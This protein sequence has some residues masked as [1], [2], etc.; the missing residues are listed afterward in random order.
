MKLSRFFGD[1]AFYETTFRI[2]LPLALST[3]LSSCMSTIDSLMASSIGM[4]TAVGNASQ[5]ITLH[6]GISFGITSGIAIFAAQFYGA[7]Q[8]DNMTRVFG[9]SLIFTLFNALVWISVFLFMGDDLLLFYLDDTQ[10][11]KYSLDYL[12][13]TIFSCIP[14]AINNSMMVAY[15]SI[16]ETKLTFYFSLLGAI[17]NV[18]FNALFIY[19]FKIGVAGAALGTIISQT[20]VMIAYLILSIKKR[21]FFLKDLR[22]IFDLR[23]SFYRPIIA[24]ML[25]LIINETLFSFGSTLFIKAF[26]LLGTKNMD[27]YYVAN[28]IY[29]LFLFIVWGYGGAVSILIGTRLGSHQI[30]R[31]KEESVY[32]ISLSLIIA[33]IIAFFIV[34]FKGPILALYSVKDPYVYNIASGLLYVLAFKAILRMLTYVIFS[35]LRAGGDAKILNFLDSGITYLLGIP[36]AFIA[37]YCGIQ[38]IVLVLLLCQIEQVVRL[39]LSLKR[40]FKGIWA[41]DLTELIEA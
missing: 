29:N 10:V 5:I 23:P 20:I 25:P 27:A 33:F 41:K 14:F 37:V 32:Q 38:S 22:L 12:S 39:I 35:T 16:H 6:D 40:Y 7:R 11:L 30:E 13:I 21:P 36:S 4:V 19:G 24:K 34:I 8:A 3:L 17:G 31:A 26:G 9:L 2:A 15:R 1:R 28:Q 18:F